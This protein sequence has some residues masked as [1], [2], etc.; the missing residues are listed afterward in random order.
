M[1]AWRRLVA[2][3]CVYLLRCSD[4]TYYTGITSDIG[5]RISEHNESSRGARYTR[6]RRPVVLVYRE[7]CDSRAAAARREWEIRKLPRADKQLLAARVDS[8]DTGL[9]ER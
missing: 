8:A 1:S 7:A 4:D 2:E 5:R 9:T 3:W 6:A